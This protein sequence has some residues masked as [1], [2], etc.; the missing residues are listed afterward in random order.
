MDGLSGIKIYNRLKINTKFLP[1]SYPKTLKFIVKGVD[2]KVSNNVWDTNISTIS[3]PVS[4][5]PPI[6]STN[7]TATGFS[8]YNVLTN[9]NTTIVKGNPLLKEVLKNAEYNPGTAS[10]ELALA[11]GTKEGWNPNANGGV[12]SRSYRNNNPGNLDFGTLAQT[13][14]PG[15]VKEDNQYGTNRFAVFSTAELGA[16]ALVETKIK[17]WSK[18][19][20]PITSGNQSLLANVTGKT[21][22]KGSPPSFREFLYTYAPPN[23]NNTEGY[24][25]TVVNNLNNVFPSANITADSIIESI[26]EIYG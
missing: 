2:H 25:N 1:S 15:A 21:Y 22:K 24:L 23:E 10:Y 6:K 17:R 11:I 13:I 14:D 16:K 26:I 8:R 18:G 5:N 7:Q 3:V 9:A 12:G 20:M 19:N 4:K